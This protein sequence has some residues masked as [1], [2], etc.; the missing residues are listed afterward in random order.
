MC[1]VVVFY[2]DVDLGKS[3][4]VIVRRRYAE[5]WY[6]LMGMLVKSQKVMVATSKPIDRSMVWYI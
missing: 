2:V 1:G 4:T 6:I 3:S 5:L